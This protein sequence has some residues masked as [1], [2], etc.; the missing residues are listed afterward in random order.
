[1]QIALFLYN[2]DMEIKCI[3][4]KL[5][6]NNLA[7]KKKILIG[8]VLSFTENPFHYELTDSV[9]IAENTAVLIDGNKIKEIGSPNQLVASAP[10]AEVYNFQEKLLCLALSMRTRT[11][12]KHQ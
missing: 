10:D 6:I 9:N 5:L 11:I 4:V 7:N 3:G 1:M 12:H 2:I 8:T